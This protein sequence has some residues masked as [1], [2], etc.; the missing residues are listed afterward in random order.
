M[1][2]AAEQTIKHLL[3]PKEFRVWCRPKSVPRNLDVTM[4]PSKATC[5]Q[6]L[7][8]MRFQTTGNRRPVSVW[9]ARDTPY[10]DTLPH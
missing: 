5:A 4:Y 10:S 9:A 7:T 6:C 1:T 2:R 3:K 8:R